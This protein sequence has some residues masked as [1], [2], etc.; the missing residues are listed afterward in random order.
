[1]VGLFIAD[2]VVN[3]STIKRCAAMLPWGASFRPTALVG[4]TKWPAIK[5]GVQPKVQSAGREDYI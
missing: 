1:M 4:A 3:F 5:N 2:M